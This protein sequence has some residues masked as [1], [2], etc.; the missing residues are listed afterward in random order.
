[1]LKTHEV[2]FSQGKPQG[3]LYIFPK[4][5][6]FQKPPLATCQ[7]CI[8]CLKRKEKEDKNRVG[9]GG[10]GGVI[11]ETDTLWPLGLGSYNSQTT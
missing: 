11:G 1:M 3:G 5:K 10:G 7:I 2:Q 4:R 9:G 8:Q 6:S